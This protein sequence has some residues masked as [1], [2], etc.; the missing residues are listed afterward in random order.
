VGCSWAPKA[1]GPAAV[2][3]DDDEDDDDGDDEDEDDED[4]DEP[5][6]VGSV[7]A[8]PRGQRS[9][10]ALQA[11]VTVERDQAVQIAW[12]AIPDPVNRRVIEVELG[13]EHGYVIW[14]VEFGYQRGHSGPDR[15][16]EVYVDVGNG[17]VLLIECEH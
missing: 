4:E 3:T 12:G 17:Q 5:Q 1:D 15:F 13:I 8:P 6:I 9:R 16:I 11:L 14:E 10:A 2:E 7:P